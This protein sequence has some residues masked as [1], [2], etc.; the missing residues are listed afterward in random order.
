[1]WIFD[2]KNKERTKIREPQFQNLQTL[3]NAVRYNAKVINLEI[4]FAAAEEIHV[5]AASADQKLIKSDVINGQH[6]GEYTIS[7]TPDPKIC[8]PKNCQQF[9]A[10][11]NV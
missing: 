5:M 2:S 11:T 4:V 10:T 3:P 8:T 7:R 9:G 1:M 6:K